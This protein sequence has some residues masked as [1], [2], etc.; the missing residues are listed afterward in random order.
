MHDVIS[1]R[2]EFRIRL[3]GTILSDTFG[4]GNMR[5]KPFSALPPGVFARVKQGTEP[6]FAPLSGNGADIDMIVA[7]SIL[8]N[9]K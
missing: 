9:R 6:C 7:V 8:E 4:D 1:G 3:I 2:E 5:G